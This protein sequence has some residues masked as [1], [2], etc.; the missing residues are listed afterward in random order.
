MIA[1]AAV[2]LV[3]VVVAELGDKTQLVAL[4]LSARYRTAQILGAL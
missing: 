1:D 3:V 4:S 2:A